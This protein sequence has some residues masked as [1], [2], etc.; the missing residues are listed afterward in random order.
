MPRILSIVKRPNK[1]DIRFNFVNDK[2]AHKD[3]ERKV[4]TYERNGCRAIELA[5]IRGHTY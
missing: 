1:L 3:I 4:L 5:M 2:V